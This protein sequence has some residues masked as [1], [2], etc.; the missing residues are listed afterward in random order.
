MKTIG[1]KAS[2]Q[3]LGMGSASLTDIA[4]PG[5]TYVDPCPVSVD[6]FSCKRFL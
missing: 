6:A 1:R 2:S 4:N 3:I 5:M